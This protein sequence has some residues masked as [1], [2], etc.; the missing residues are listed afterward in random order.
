M[1]NPL[2]ARRILWTGL[3]FVLSCRAP[4][5]KPPEPPGR[6]T[7]TQAKAERVRGVRMLRISG[8]VTR[9]DT[10]EPVPG[11]IINVKTRTRF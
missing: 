9:K 11:V 6:W 4:T 8:K 1:R 10:G 5:P 2:P 7:L 3:L